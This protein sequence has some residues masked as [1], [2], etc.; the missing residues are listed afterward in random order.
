MSEVL[1]NF[2]NQRYVN[3]IIFGFFVL[4]RPIEAASV[5]LEDIDNKNNV[6]NI[7]KTKTGINNF[8]VPITPEFKL[9]LDKICDKERP[10]RIFK[11]APETI[12]SKTLIELKNITL[13]LCFMV[14][15]LREWHGWFIM[16][17]TYSQLKHV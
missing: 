16:A 12:R 15:E 6:I 13:I 1:S 2:K 14:G 8:K 7:K 11:I 3:Y 4:V 17:L 10:G 5:E 9:L